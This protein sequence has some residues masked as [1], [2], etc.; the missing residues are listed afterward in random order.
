MSAS[1]SMSH[2]S[3]SGLTTTGDEAYGNG[4]NEVNS[5]S[6]F[7]SKVTCFG[8]LSFEEGK[9]IWVDDIDNFNIPMFQSFSSQPQVQMPLQKRYFTII[10]T[11]IMPRGQ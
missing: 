8:K 2:A 3:S 6:S 4:E 1:G 7:E 9:S 10:L 5:N 11:P